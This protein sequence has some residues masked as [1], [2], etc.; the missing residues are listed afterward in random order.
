M[1]QHN[2]MAPIKK[3]ARQVDTSQWVGLRIPGRVLSSYVV[4]QSSQ[5]RSL[6]LDTDTFFESETGDCNSLVIS[7]S[8]LS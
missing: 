7:G 1:K 3:H 6:K 4:A 5:G 2:G 8:C